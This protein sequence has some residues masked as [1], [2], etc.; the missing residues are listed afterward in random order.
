ME[1]QSILLRGIARVLNAG[2]CAL[3]SIY[4]AATSIRIKTRVSPGEKGNLQA[5]L[6]ESEKRIE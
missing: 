3:L 5:Q 6:D 1:Q 4:D 2:G